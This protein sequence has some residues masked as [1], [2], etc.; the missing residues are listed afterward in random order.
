MKTTLAIIASILLSPLLTL[1]GRADEPP[2]SLVAIDADEPTPIR[3][4]RSLNSGLL[5]EPALDL[6]W[7]TREKFIAE[8]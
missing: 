5:L 8:I 2:T 6:S 3:P 4:A 1:G 7:F